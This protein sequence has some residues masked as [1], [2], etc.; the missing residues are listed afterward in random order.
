MSTG[1][2]T[3]H[4]LNAGK[5]AGV[6]ACPLSRMYQCDIARGDV[7]LPVWYCRLRIPFTSVP[8]IYMHCATRTVR[9]R[10]HRPTGQQTLHH[11]QQHIA[12]ALNT[13]E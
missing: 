13:S 10:P 7:R 1:T 9:K 4:T 11:V 3:M 8:L 12:M 2:H 6:C 5:C